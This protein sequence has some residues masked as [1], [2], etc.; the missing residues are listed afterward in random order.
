M[1]SLADHRWEQAKIW[2]PLLG[3]ICPSHHMASY[4]PLSCSIHSLKVAYMTIGFCSCL[5]T[6]RR[7]NR[8]IHGDSERF[9]VEG[10]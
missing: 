9:Q 7:R 2:D 5:H 6:G 1:E 8:S 10:D 4:S 3:D